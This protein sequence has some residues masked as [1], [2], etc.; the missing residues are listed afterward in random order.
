VTKWARPKGLKLEAKRA[1]NE[2]GMAE[3]VELLWRG[4]YPL[5]N[6]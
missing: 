5:P 2:G 3:R 4:S 1:K 6:S